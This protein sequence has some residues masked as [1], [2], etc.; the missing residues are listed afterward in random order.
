MNDNKN[1]VIWIVK[2]QHLYINLILKSSF[3]ILLKDKGKIMLV[4]IKGIAYKF[5]KLFKNVTMVL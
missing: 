4:T 1:N 2:Y 5:S 3:I